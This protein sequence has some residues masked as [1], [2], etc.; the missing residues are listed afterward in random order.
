VEH[1]LLEVEKVY[2]CARSWALRMRL[3]RGDV[4]L[5]ELTGR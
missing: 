4:T 3:E 2:G 5:N 1:Y